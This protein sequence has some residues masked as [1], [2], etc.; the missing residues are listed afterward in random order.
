VKLFSFWG[1]ILGFTVINFFWELYWFYSFRALCRTPECFYFNSFPIGSL[2]MVLFAWMIWS[3]TKPTEKTIY[4]DTPE[5]LWEALDELDPRK[6]K[7]KKK[8]TKKRKKK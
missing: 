4:Y 5:Q 3:M 1:F 6:K 7:A 2:L 8:T